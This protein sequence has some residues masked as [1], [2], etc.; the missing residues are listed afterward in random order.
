LNALSPT[1]TFSVDNG[2]TYASPMNSNP[3]TVANN[4]I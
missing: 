2:Q 4:K 3:V 1:I